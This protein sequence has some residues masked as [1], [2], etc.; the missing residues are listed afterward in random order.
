M[1][2][3]VKR[4]LS[5]IV[6]VFVGMAMQTLACLVSRAVDQNLF[7]Y[8]KEKLFGPLGMH[9]ARPEGPKRRRLRLLVPGD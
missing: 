8:A 4:V 9:S 1:N 6:C 2:K 7:D 3:S 5:A